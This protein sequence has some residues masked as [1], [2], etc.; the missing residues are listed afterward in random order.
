[1]AGG[2]GAAEEAQ[3]Q[4]GFPEEV[5]DLGTELK[6]GLLGLW[7]RREGVPVAGTAVQGQR[8]HAGQEAWGGRV[9]L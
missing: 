1:M 8:A 3:S 6:G 4:R 9:A 2:G 7:M 5:D